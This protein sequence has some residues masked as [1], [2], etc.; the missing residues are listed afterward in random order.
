MEIPIA[1]LKSTDRNVGTSRKMFSVGGCHNTISYIKREKM[2]LSIRSSR[3][4]TR[5]KIP[6]IVS[7]MGPKKKTEHVVKNGSGGVTG[8]EESLVNIA[9][10]CALCHMYIS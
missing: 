1:K 4:D 10:R 3:I 7:G 8:A 5:V 6:E 9:T 2:C